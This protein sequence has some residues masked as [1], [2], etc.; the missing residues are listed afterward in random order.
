SQRVA[1]QNP[2]WQA[3]PAGQ[4]FTADGYAKGYGRYSQDVL[5]PAFVAAYTKKDPNGVALIRQSNPNISANPFGGIIPKPNWKV[6]YTGLSKL[7]ALAKIFTS[8]NISHGYNGNLSMNSFNSALLYQDP[9]RFSAP[10]FI[11]TV[12]GNFVPYFLVPNITIKENFE[13]LIGFDVTTVDNLSLTFRYAKSRILSLS[14]I[15]YQLSES[16]STEW[17]FGAGLKKKGVKLPFRLPGSKGKVLQNDLN[18]RLDLSMR[19][20]STSNSRLDQANAYGTG[21]QKEITIQPSIDYVLNNRINIKL[22]FDQRRTIP[23]I[24][25]SAPMT[26]TRAGINIRVSLAQ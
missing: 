8:I 14:L 10:G 1:A 25:T 24:S 12:S 4:K 26:N 3:L 15:D 7:P 13:P 11:D 2:Y 17:V 19:D 23:Y 20:V 9:F 18:L 16:R 21:G 5:V 22:F 6:S